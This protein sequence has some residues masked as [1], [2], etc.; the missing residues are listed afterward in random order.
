[1]EAPDREATITPVKGS[2][3]EGPGCSKSEFVAKVSPDAIDETRT[4][5][6]YHRAEYLYEVYNR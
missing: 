6:P 2:I 3:C 5:C 4:L 1:M